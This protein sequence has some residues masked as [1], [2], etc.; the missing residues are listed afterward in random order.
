MKIIER[1]I[2]IQDDFI[3]VKLSTSF[4]KELNKNLEKIFKPIISKYISLNK[5]FVHIKCFPEQIEESGIMKCSNFSIN[6][7]YL[8]EVSGTLFWK[9]KKGNLPINLEDEVEKDSLDFWV[10]DFNYERLI[11]DLKENAIL[12]NKVFLDGFRF[13]VQIRQISINSELLI[14]LSESVNDAIKKNLEEYLHHKI[15]I[16]NQD[17]T[18]NKTGG[19]IHSI[20]LT[21][22][23]K[24]KCLKFCIDYGSSGEGGIYQIV[25]ILN[26]SIFPIEK[27]EIVGK[28]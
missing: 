3:P 11:K 17:N 19:V 23:K 16:F 14:F 10:E 21:E 5:M 4:K 20:N 9:N 8:Y 22:Y 15:N 6:S 12:Q 13:I 27:V 7:P 18:L 28:S 25:K 26:E 24:D 1:S 2:R